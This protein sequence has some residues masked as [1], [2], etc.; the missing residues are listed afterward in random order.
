MSFLHQERHQ[1]RQQKRQQRGPYTTKACTNCQ[2]KHAKCTGE[3]PCERCTRLNLVCTFSDSGKKRGPKKNAKLPEE[4][5]ALNNLRNDFDRT[6][7]QF[8]VISDAVQGHTSTLSSP[9]GYPEQS[10][11]IAHFS[12]SYE[13]QNVPAFQEVCPVLYQASID[14]GYVMPNNILLDN[15]STNINVY[16]YV[17]FD[18]YDMLPFDH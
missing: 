1:Q 12:D 6:H 9:T 3:V 2:Q 5:Y 16:D 8:F 11:G 18:D 4:V 15:T 17:F 14:A 7:M 10:Y 13:E